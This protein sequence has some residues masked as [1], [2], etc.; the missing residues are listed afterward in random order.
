MQIVQRPEELQPRERRVALAIGTFDGVHLG[1]QQVL[2]QALCDAEQRE[3]LAIAVTFD[4]H[5]ASVVAPERVPPLI[6]TQAAKLRAIATLG[7]HAT[8]EIPFT[9]EFRAWSGDEFIR[10][11]AKGFGAVTSISVGDNFVFGRGRSGNVEMLGRLG[12]ELGFQVRGIAAVALGGEPVSSTRI[13]ESIRRGN[14]DIASQMLGREYALSATVEQG[15]QLGRRIGFPTAN[16][17]VQG[18]VVP[19]PGVYAAHAY[20]GGRSYRAAVN[21][22]YRPTVRSSG[23][24]QLRVEAHLL[25]FSGDIYGAEMELT[26]V[27]KLRDEKKFGGLEELQAQIR[28][29]IAN[30]RQQFEKF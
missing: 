1:H 8:L 19:P 29:D 16:L 23:E 12:N 28:E 2:R 3:G 18:L 15:D 5:P 11:L 14:L 26:F 13:R 27:A 21:I 9:N 22:G 25:D 4:R 17:A 30:A 24:P 20:V 10:W 7:M 6:Q